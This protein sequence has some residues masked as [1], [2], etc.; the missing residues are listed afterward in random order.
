MGG[1]VEIFAPAKLNLHL[2]VGPAGADG[3]H[4]VTTVL[5]AIGLGDTVIVGEAAGLS[6]RCAPDL[7]IP[8]TE[9]LAYRAAASFAAACGREPAVSVSVRKAIP[10]GAGLGGGSSDA[11]AVVR[12]MA[13]LWGVPLSDPSV[14]RAA[15]ALGADVPFFLGAPAALMT[16]RGDVLE[17]ELDA[18]VFHVAVVWPRVTVSTADA[19]AAFDA[20]TPRATADPGRLMAALEGGDWRE[21][22]TLLHNDMTR[23]SIGLVPAIGDALALLRGAEGVAGAEMCGSGSAVFG[24]CATEAAARLVA[25]EA[26]ERGWWAVATR[27]A[28]GAR[29]IGA[30]ERRGSPTRGESAG[31]RIPSE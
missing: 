3:Y 23:S 6:F 18:P 25:D 4:E 5:Q 31:G 21:V 20:S 28:G 2:S 11:A 8:D 26:R 16:G 19:Y 17:R 30:D 10:A 13:R 1:E 27:S 7:G 24:V 12:G 29:T 22:A 9:N 14:G 15:A